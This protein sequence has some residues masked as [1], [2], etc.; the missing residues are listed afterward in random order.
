[1]EEIRIN[2]Y[3]ISEWEKDELVKLNNENIMF[4]PCWYKPF[5]LGIELNTLNDDDFILHKQL[6]DTFEVRNMEEIIIMDI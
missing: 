6:F 2:V 5:G 1:M 3:P 4:I